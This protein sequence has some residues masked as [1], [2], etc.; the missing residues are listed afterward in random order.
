[1]EFHHDGPYVNIWDSD[2]GISVQEQG[3]L[4][5][6]NDSDV[7]VSSGQLSHIDDE[8]NQYQLTYTADENGYQPKGAHLPTPPPIPQAILEALEYIRTHPAYD[9]NSETVG[10]V[11]QLIVKMAQSHFVLRVYL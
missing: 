5:R 10:Q 2:N 11:N 9:D 4:A 1:M 6:I 7:V 3:K 8:G